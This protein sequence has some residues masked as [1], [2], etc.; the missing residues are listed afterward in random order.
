M[1]QQTLLHPRRNFVPWQLPF[2]RSYNVS[3][4]DCGRRRSKPDADWGRFLSTGRMLGREP[5]RFAV[6]VNQYSHGNY[7]S[8]D[9]AL[10]PGD[11]LVV[12]RRAS[13][14]API[15]PAKSRL[16]PQPSAAR[17]EKKDGERGV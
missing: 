12:P 3:R 6:E 15:Q 14:S 2:T 10:K 7:P 1:R 4:G 13:D 5:K 11:R 17:L 9:D 8:A 16:L